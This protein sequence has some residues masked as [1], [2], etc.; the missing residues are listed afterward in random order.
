MMLKALGACIIITTALAPAPG[1][2][3]TTPGSWETIVDKTPC[4]GANA[5]SGIRI[6][7]PLITSREHKPLHYGAPKMIINYLKC[8]YLNSSCVLE[9]TSESKACNLGSLTWI[10]II[11]Q[12]GYFY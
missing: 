11:G 7:D 8:K 1:Y 9:E 3:F 5:P 2:P 10:I 6:L 4:L 12:V